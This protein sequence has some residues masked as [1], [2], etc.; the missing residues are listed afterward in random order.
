LIGDFHNVVDADYVLLGYNALMVGD[1]YI[2]FGG[3][4]ASEYSETSVTSDQST[5][6]H[7]CKGTLLPDFNIRNLD[8]SL[9][10]KIK[11]SVHVAPVG[12]WST[13]RYM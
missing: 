11:S 7:I 6:R 12:V 3:V 9:T 1:F 5:Q 10:F 8:V 4:P 13:S 2:R